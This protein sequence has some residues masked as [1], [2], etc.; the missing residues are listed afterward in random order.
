MPAMKKP[1]QRRKVERGLCGGAL[2]AAEGR[3]LAPGQQEGPERRPRPR[4]A[5]GWASG[6]GSWA[7]GRARR[8]GLVSD[9]STAL[10]LAN[11]RKKTEVAV[12][13][14]PAPLE[15]VRMRP[16]GGRRRLVG[17]PGEDALRHGRG[18]PGG[19]GAKTCWRARWTP[20]SSG[21]ASQASSARWPASA[22]RP[23]GRL[24]LARRRSPAAARAR[25]ARA[26]APPASAASSAARAAFGR[27]L[28]GRPGC[29]PT[30]P[31]TG[32]TPCGRRTRAR[33][34]RAG[35]RGGLEPGRRARHGVEG[36]VE[37]AARVHDVEGL[38]DQ[39]VEE[40]GGVGERLADPVGPDDGEAVA[41]EEELGARARASRAGR[42]PTPG[43]SAAPSGGCRRWARP[44]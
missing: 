42:P 9:E 10:T 11:P 16:C 12:A 2:V 20:S 34:R 22:Q 43:G 14:G 33:R 8:D 4:P 31:R 13:S 6:A 21:R 41:G 26:P 32:A 25:S 1:C 17:G 27:R 28:A 40:V 15:S 37:P 18:G 39:G 30:S 5:D 19:P 23:V 3:E 7:F 44:R 24:G 36:L 29:R 35:G 38:V